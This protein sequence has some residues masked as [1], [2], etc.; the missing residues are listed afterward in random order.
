MCEGLVASGV[1]DWTTPSSSLSSARVR[2]S[3]AGR[4]MEEKKEIRD[5]EGRL[6]MSD[7]SGQTDAGS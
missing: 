2:K 3:S 6:S 7:A 1:V 5:G 4:G